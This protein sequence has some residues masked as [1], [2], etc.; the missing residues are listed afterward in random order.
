MTIPFSDYP[1]LFL[2]FFFLMRMS[3]QLFLLASLLLATAKASYRASAIFVNHGPGSMPYFQPNSPD[4][5]PLIDNWVGATKQALF[6]AGRPRAILVV[7]AHWEENHVSI[8][9]YNSPPPLFD[10]LGPG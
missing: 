7:N 4:V 1:F 8:S 6:S 5:I 2:V 10:D 9:S 3:L